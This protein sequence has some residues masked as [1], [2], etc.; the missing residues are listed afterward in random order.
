MDRHAR[1]FCTLIAKNASDTRL[2]HTQ[3]SMCDKFISGCVIITSIEKQGRTHWVSL[4]A[5][6]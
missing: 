2:L 4:Q 3:F 1:H 5:D 6:F